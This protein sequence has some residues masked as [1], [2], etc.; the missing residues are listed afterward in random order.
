MCLLLLPEYLFCEANNI[1]IA[2]ANLSFVI[3]YYYLMV[4]G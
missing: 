3:K 2:T 1:I 4:S